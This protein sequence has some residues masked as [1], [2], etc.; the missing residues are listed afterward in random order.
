MNTVKKTVMKEHKIL[1]VSGGSIEDDFV[2]DLI[3]KNDYETVIACDS[4][5]EFFKRNG[6]CPNLIL[7]DFDSAD[8]ESVAF[9]RQQTGV[10]ME[11]FPAEKD[12]TDT[13]LALRRALEL[14]P[15]HIDL[16]GATGSRLDH[17]LGNLCLLTLGL[18]SGTEIFL[19]DSHNRIRMIEGSL[20]IR[21]SEQYGSFVSL[22]PYAGAVRELTLRGMKYP[23]EDAAL[24]PGVSLGISNEIVEETALIDFA[25]GM[26]FVIE[27]RD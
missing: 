19:L 9:F 6:I 25:E 2:R 27:S 17:V 24:M 7:G 5:M 15:D 22:I 4:G 13:E 1:I 26:L 16:V 14:A 11:Q 8:A 23:L 10:R 18:E 3:Q 21:K 12:W 20:T